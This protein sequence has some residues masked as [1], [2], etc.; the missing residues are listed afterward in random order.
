VFGLHAVLSTNYGSPVITLTLPNNTTLPFSVDV[1]CSGIY[2]LIG[3]AIFAL[4]IAY[5]RP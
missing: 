1:A 3:F 2:S 5:I 4:F